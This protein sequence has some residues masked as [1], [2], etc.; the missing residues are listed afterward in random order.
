MTQTRER[1]EFLSGRKYFLVVSGL[2]LVAL[3]TRIFCL[4]AQSLWLDEAISAIV[5][6][7][8]L[9][10]C[11]QFA[12]GDL[13]PPLYYILLHFWSLI[14]RDEF[15]LRLFSVVTNLL[16]GTILFVW[17]RRMFNPSIA[18]LTLIFFAVSPFQIRYSQEVRMY[19]ILGLWIVL[20]LLLV[21]RYLE[22]ERLIFLLG[23]I[24]FSSLG[25]YTHYQTGIFLV[26]INIAIFIRLYLMGRGRLWRWT[27]AQLTILALFS[28]WLP[29][30]ISQ[31]RG[32]G[33]SWVPFDPSFHAF[34]SPV[35]VFL[36]G[37]PIL[38]RIHHTFYPVFPWLGELRHMIPW[39]SKSS[40]IIL[41]VF[42]ILKIW[43]RRKRDLRLSWPIVF[44]GFL[45]IGTLGL[46]YV[47]SFKMN[48]QGAKYLIGTSFVFYIFVAVVLEALNR[49][50]RKMGMVLGMAVILTQ[51]FMLIL[52]YLPENHRENW[53]DAV[54]YIEEHSG[55]GQAV[56]FH[57]D[58][59]M[60]PYV[61]YAHGSVPA[62]GFLKEGKLSPSLSTVIESGRNT[63]WLFDYLAELYDPKGIVKEKLAQCGY[64]PSWHH[65]FNGVALTAWIKATEPIE[66]IWNRW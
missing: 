43:M 8:P 1:V 56:G 32:G 34:I 3:G 63:I 31:L 19:S 55:P 27:L 42:V 36:W 4:S 65:N 33:R 54:I 29:N 28:P 7:S 23:Y 26:L 21:W 40:L 12:K 17:V 9:E 16:T 15:T 13:H 39:V 44:I 66:N 62:Y 52:Y 20:I 10:S 18:L 61:Y 45:L 60:A 46:C 30:F 41:F 59:P 53:R 57:F 25:L 24:I 2:I 37:E 11:I 35:F 49:G 14:S 5:A 47:L 58:S 51:V 64:V 38:S 22:S 48:I 6:L 50:N